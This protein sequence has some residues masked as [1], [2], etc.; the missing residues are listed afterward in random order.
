MIIKE[1]TANDPKNFN[2]N[3]LWQRKKGRAIIM[4]L[5]N[6]WCS[7]ETCWWFKISVR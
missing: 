7:N 6:H 1:T 5:Q 3:F 4:Q 2:I